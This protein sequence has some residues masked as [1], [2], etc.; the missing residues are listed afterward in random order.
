LQ[1]HLYAAL[2]LCLVNTPNEDQ[3]TRPW[4]LAVLLGTDRDPWRKQLWKAAAARDGKQVDQLLR[5][6]DVPTQPPSLV[7]FLVSQ[8]R[9]PR[10]AAERVN[11]LQRVQRA[12]PEDF[13]ANFCLALEL[14]HAGR[15]GE[16]VPYYTAAL[17]LRP[18]NAGV[19]VNRSIA[20]RETK[21]LG[22]A[23]A[24]AQQ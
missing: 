23:I 19:Y 4:L 15:P 11:L 10:T 17:A 8:Y 24:D 18:R 7:L 5:D 1:G 12:N 16:A 6:L 20:W 2:H 9:W 22:E 21:R 3:Q 13:W 14:V